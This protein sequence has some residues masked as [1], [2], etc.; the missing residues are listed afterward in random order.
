MNV[1]DFDKTIYNGDSTVDF[2]LF[3]LKKKPLLIRHLPTQVWGVV[4]Y[5]LGKIDKTKLKEKF[6]SFVKSI[7]CETYVAEFWNRNKKKIASWYIEQQQNDDVIISASP[8][9]LLRPVCGHLGIKHLIASDVDPKTGEFL[10]ENCYGATK[11]ERFQEVFGDGEIDTFY[12][13]SFSDF[14]MARIANRAFLIVKGNVTEWSQQNADEAFRKEQKNVGDLRE[15]I[16]YLFFG[17]GTVGVNVLSYALLYDVLKISNLWSSLIAWLV[18]VIFAYV[19]N[20]KYVFGTTP[21][22][23]GEY[24]KEFLNFFTCRTLTGVLDIVIMLIAVDYMHW[25]DVV[26]KLISSI[27][28]T[29]VNY[30]AS[31]YFIFSKK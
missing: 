31:K 4:L 12:S 13:D 5:L 27:I 29:I 21:S 23:A 18:A 10:S 20:Q 16:L 9:F 2:Y 14:P 6:F 28:V 11:V 30:F 22:S 17:F 24:A 8:D 15:T 19:T 3:S 7:D 1:Y 26:W 25:N